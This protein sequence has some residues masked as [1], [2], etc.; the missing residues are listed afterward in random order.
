MRSRCVPELAQTFDDP[1]TFQLIISLTTSIDIT[2][3][4]Q[5]VEHRVQGR[6]EIR[7]DSGVKVLEKKTTTQRNAKKT[8]L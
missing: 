8:Q 1:F 3:T 2:Y 6:K 5:G 4:K 7:M